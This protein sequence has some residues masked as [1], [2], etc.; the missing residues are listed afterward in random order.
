MNVVDTRRRISPTFFQVMSI[1]IFLIGVLLFVLASNNAGINFLPRITEAGGAGGGSFDYCPPDYEDWSPQNVTNYA[2]AINTSGYPDC[3]YLAV[4]WCESHYIWNAFNGP[5]R[6]IYQFDYNTWTDTVNRY[7]GSQ[8]A[9]ADICPSP[10][11][12]TFTVV[13]SNADYMP[14]R[15]IWSP[16]RQA[17]A[18]NYWVNQ[19]YTGKWSCWAVSSC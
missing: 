7:L 2:A 11:P 19:G 16:F 10:V 3:K 9:T 15:H 14:D 5:W 18:F 4:M 17:G 1:L 13:S 8:Y 6:G 12:T